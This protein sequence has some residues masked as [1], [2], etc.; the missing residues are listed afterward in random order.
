MIDTRQS[1]IQDNEKTS[2]RLGI[3]ETTNEMFGG[4]LNG[5]LI[6]CDVTLQN[7]VVAPAVLFIFIQLAV[8]SQ[9]LFPGYIPI[10]AC[11][12]SPMQRR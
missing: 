7:I 6:W 11:Q 12:P 9:L 10:P 5:S 8:Q 2:G 3:G 1:Y 4:I